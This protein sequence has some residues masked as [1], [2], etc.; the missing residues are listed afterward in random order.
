MV[1]DPVHQTIQHRHLEP[2]QMG[3]SSDDHVPSGEH[4]LRGKATVLDG[5]LS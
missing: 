4:L 3:R 1:E 2:E 5:K